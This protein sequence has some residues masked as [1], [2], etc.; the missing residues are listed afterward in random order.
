MQSSNSD[1]SKESHTAKVKHSKAKNITTTDKQTDPAK[2]KHA[3]ANSSLDASTG[4]NKDPKL[5][6][7]DD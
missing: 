1:T 4:D 2:R 7:D 6:N 5:S 3:E